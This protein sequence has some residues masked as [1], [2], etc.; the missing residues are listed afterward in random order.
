MAT[1]CSRTTRG[2][3]SPS[4]TACS[5]RPT[6]RASVSSARRLLILAEG[7]SGD[8]HFGKTA[9]GVIRYRPQ[10]VV[11]VLDSARAASDHED[12]PLVHA[13]EHAMAFEPTT[14][15]VGVATQG[16]PFPPAWRELLQD[17]IRSG[18]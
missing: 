1:C 3:A 12:C 10:D 6:G 2:R 5:F 14:A 4:R 9:R 18:L 16:G 13:V 11:C 15:L 8:P 7:R 17:C